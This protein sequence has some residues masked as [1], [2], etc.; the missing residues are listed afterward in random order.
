MGFLDKLFG[1]ASTKSPTRDE[2]ARLIADALHKAGEKA[3]LRYDA[4]E[5]RLLTEG[6]SPHIFNLINAY[7]EYCATP[8][9]N[10]ANVFRN[11][12]RTW[13]AHQH[14]EA[15]ES[16]DDVHPDLLPTVRSRSYYERAKLQM[17]LDGMPDADWPYLVLAEHFAIGLVYDL[18]ESMMMIQQHHLTD[19]GVTFEDA[20]EAACKNLAEISQHQFETPAPGVWVSPWRDNHD[21][22]RLLLAGLIEHHEVQGAP[23]AVIPNRDT[24]ILTGSEDEAGLARMAALAEK[25]REHPRPISCIPLRLEDD[26][27]VPFMPEQD[28]PQFAAFKMLWIQSLGMDYED[29][30]EGLKALYEKTG[31]DIFVATFSAVKMK[32]TGQVVSYCVWSQ[33]VDSL[34]PRTDQIF[35]FRP[36]GAE[37][38]DIVATPTWE[39][40]QEAAGSLLEKTDMYPERYRVKSFPTEQQLAAL[41]SAD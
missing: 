12:I 10:R 24:L 7:N 13:F 30:A 21:T 35:F 18:P 38:G 15:P 14:K 4:T 17:K 9:D 19:W 11:F 34:L 6:E 20:L 22:A 23:V 3:E 29:Q 40:V 25:A 8:A 32:E 27:W 41:G 39:Q 16:F 26:H 31:E 37:N 36:S 5:F 2:F 1:R 28:H 33:G